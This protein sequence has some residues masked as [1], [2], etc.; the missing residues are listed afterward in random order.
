M[1]LQISLLPCLLG[2][3]VIAKRLNELQ[4]P[5]APKTANRYRSWIDNYVAEDYS[6]AVVKGC[7]E[8]TQLSNKLLPE[9]I[10]QPVAL[11][12]KGALKQSP[13]RIEELVKIFIHAT[14]VQ[15]GSYTSRVNKLTS[16][17][18][19]DRLLGYGLDSV[20]IDALRFD[21]IRSRLIVLPRSLGVK[22]SVL[23]PNCRHGWSM[24]D[25]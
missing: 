14:K 18:D 10:R 13:T 15:I 11:V 16:N 6:A 2:Y 21:D 20:K 17:I 23:L 1:A 24:Q 5:G 9:L 25:G 8:S 19:G 7:G 22:C 4:E 3:H 12:E